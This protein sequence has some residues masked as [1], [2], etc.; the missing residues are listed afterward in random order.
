MPVTHSLFTTQYFSGGQGVTEGLLLA[1]S[2][3][4]SDLARLYA[5]RVSCRPKADCHEN[6]LKY[7]ISLSLSFL[8]MNLLFNSVIS[9]ITP[10]IQEIYGT[11]YLC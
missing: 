10:C 5:L 9:C 4:S 11:V 7:I 8:Q 3:L 2:C 6:L 1:D